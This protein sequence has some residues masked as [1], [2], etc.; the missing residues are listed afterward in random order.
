MEQD[1]L[2]RCGLWLRLPSCFRCGFFMKIKRCIVLSILASTRRQLYLFAGS[3]LLLLMVVPVAAFAAEALQK[4]EPTTMRFWVACLA[5][6][7]LNSLG[8]AASSLPELANWI[9]DGGTAVER[10]TR[11]F[12]IIR[13]CCIAALAGNIG[14][15]GGLYYMGVAEVGCF[16][17]AA[18][19]AYG[20]DKFLTPLLSRITGASRKND[21]D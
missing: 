21:D 9:D 11:K 13:G 16:I 6:Q 10:L 12:K 4:F 7:F 3:L 8:Y 20:G 17:A 5:V 1:Q 18:V 2:A 15:Y 19:C 14:Y